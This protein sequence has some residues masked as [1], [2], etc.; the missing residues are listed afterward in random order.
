MRQPVG[1]AIDLHP[2]CTAQVGFH[3]GAAVQGAHDVATVNVLVHQALA[4]HVGNASHQPMEAHHQLINPGP[5]PSACHA[6]CARL[7][8]GQTCTAVTA[9]SHR[10]AHRKYWLRR[11]AADAC[12]H[13]HA[14]CFVVCCYCCWKDELTAAAARRVIAQ[15]DRQAIIEAAGVMEEAYGV[16]RSCSRLYRGGPSLCKAR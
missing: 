12:L 11:Q 15:V 8:L 1:L 10:F 14:Y 5:A 2:G 9:C 6:S 16:A 7:F 4:V 13:L 3:P